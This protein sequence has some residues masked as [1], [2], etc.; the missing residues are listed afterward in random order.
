MNAMNGLAGISLI[1][2]NWT[3]AVA[4]YREALQA[5]EEHKLKI[6]GPLV[7]YKIKTDTLQKLHTTT[8]LAEVL[9][10]G[11]ADI[12]PTLR[13]STLRDECRQLQSNYLAKYINAGRAAKVG[14]RKD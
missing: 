4:K 13:D 9:E 12:V 7:Y 2:E 10:A 8:N 11:H 1:E 3:E 6:P 14:Q 5:I